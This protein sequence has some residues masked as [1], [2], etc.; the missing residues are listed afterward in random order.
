MA[1]QL[2]V[3]LMQAHR[4]FLTPTSKPTSLSTTAMATRFPASTTKKTRPR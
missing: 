1:L 3:D 2:L 4:K